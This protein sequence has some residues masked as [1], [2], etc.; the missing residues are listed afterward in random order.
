MPNMD[1]NAASHSNE[2]FE[3]MATYE[4]PLPSPTR[5]FLPWHRPR[6]QFVRSRQWEGEIQK[7]FDDFPLEDEAVISYLGLPGVDLLD[8]RHFHEKICEQRQ[9]QMRFLGFNSGAGPGTEEHQDMNLS[10]DEVR[11]LELIDEQSEV[12]WDDFVLLAERDSR[13]YARA[14]HHGPYDI[15]NLDLCDGFGKHQAGSVKNTYYNAIASLLQIQ[16][17]QPK[18]WLLFLTTRADAPTVDANVLQ[19]VTTKY[20]QNLAD[21]IDFKNLSAAKFNI[22]TEAELAAALSTTPGHLRV[23]LTGLSKWLI[24]LALQCTPKIGVHLVSAM[25]Y[26]VV[27]NADEVDLI[28]L[29]FRF[30]P[31]E[32]PIADP[33]G[34]VAS[35]I[36]PPD[37]APLALKALNKIAGLKDI[38]KLLASNNSLRE[39]MVADMGRLVRAA[40]YDE[41]EYSQWAATD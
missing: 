4:A 15:V 12:L 36:K 16:C 20:R 21:H 30:V 3:G 28:S 2:I 24:S 10:L 39:E 25:G 11:R 14:L 7:F 8:L 33:V 31:S 38:D 19:A 17:R 34:L 18:P 35:T 1:E 9:R 37:E 13:A 5:A 41:N 32:A 27:K 26:K 6:K 29:A 22:A 40:R 23:F